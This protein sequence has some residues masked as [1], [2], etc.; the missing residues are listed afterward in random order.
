[1][2]ATHKLVVS[3]LSE[4]LWAASSKQVQD[5]VLAME[6]MIPATELYLQT[7]VR[8]KDLQ[9]LAIIGVKNLDES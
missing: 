5:K 6:R 9:I 4:D 8:K 1:M 7:V 3:K 2:E